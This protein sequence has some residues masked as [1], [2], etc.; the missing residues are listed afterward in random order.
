MRAIAFLW[1]LFVIAFLAPAPSSAQLRRGTEPSLTPA[2]SLTAPDDA[3]AVDVNP[4]ALAFLPTWSLVY[5][6]AQA[7]SDA[8]FTREGD[9]LRAA[10]PL[11]FGIS[12]GASVQSIR[13][14]DAS[15]EA[16]RGMFSVALAYALSQSLGIGGALRFFASDQDSTYAGLITLD[17]GLSWRLAANIAA[18]LVV[19]DVFG[20]LDLAAASQPASFLL[21]FGLRPFGSRVFSLDVA[22]AVDTDGTVGI[23]GAAELTV[24]YLGRLAGAVEV[25]Q[26]DQSDPEVLVTGGLTVDWGRVGIGGGAIGGTEFDGT[27]GFYGS[28]HLEGAQRE[29]IPTGGYLADIRVPGV[30]ARGIVG[31]VWQLDR[32]LLDDDVRGVVLRFRGSGIGSAYAQEIRWMIDR[33]QEADKPVFC[34]L[35][36]GSG[37]EFYA[38]ATA[39]G[40]YVDPAGGFRLVGTSSTS[41]LLGDLLRT[42]GLRTDFVRIGRYK[43]APEQFT[44]RVPSAGA[45]EQREALYEDV[46]QRLLRD[47]GNDLDRPRTEIAEV[48]DRGPYLTEEA[49]DAGL[50]SGPADGFDLGDTLREA[51]GE[52]YPRL[53]APPRRYPA[54]WHQRRVAVVMIDGDI[55]DGENSDIPILGLRMTGGRTMVGLI[56]R[57]A[58]D[59]GVGAIL[60]RVD[61]PGGSA[62]ASD[63]IWRALQR[64]RRRKPVICSMGAV[65]AS[66]GY[67]VAAATDEIWADP[68]TVT[69]SIGIFFGK[70][71]VQPLADMI[72]V[73]IHRYERGRHSGMESIYRPFSSEERALLADKIRI[74][75]RLFLSRIAEGR[76][77]SVVEIDEHA[78]GRVWS[79]D[80]AH[81]LGLVDHLGGFGAALQ[82]A[83]QLGDLPP[84]A[85]ISLEPW[86]PSTLLD[87]ILG[88]IFAGARVDPGAIDERFSDA[89]VAGLPAPVL[90]ALRV[91]VA[92]G[93]V[94][95]G[96]PHARLESTGSVD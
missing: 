69:G 37:A 39:N 32:A 96:I 17:L 28:A 92:M 45:M 93:Q 16:S 59:P 88:D 86:R 52:R 73:G 42:V 89:E 29:G 72:G 24:P 18:S 47:L 71:D 87:Y 5:T 54:T 78:R 74:W 61:S 84:D 15:G 33:L 75:Y 49:T 12:A 6:H 91:A 81:G 63:Q 3:L 67:Y 58:A 64:A 44:N 83:R 23:R 53:E 10:T 82:R 95:E 21:S 62:L 56:D 50:I 70:V 22:G 35:E 1:A 19:R 30:G 79:G 26:L 25:S 20:P 46:Y 9:A 27:L 77:M 11:L 85:P 65:A 13:P 4:A 55:V 76:G 43:S 57:L 90:E 36:A 60:V 8:E 51:F 66:G 38:C 80:S 14:T 7:L 40:T 34:H 94:T 41:L 48:I 2:V 31:L 68:A